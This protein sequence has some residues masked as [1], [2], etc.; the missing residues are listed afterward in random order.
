MKRVKLLV[1][2]FLA[3]VLTSGIALAGTLDD[4]R[5]RGHLIAGVNGGV[6]G[7]SMPD[8]KGV[9]KGLDVDTARAIAV[10]ALARKESRGAHYREDFPNE[11]KNWI[12]HISVR[13]KKGIPDISRIYPLVTN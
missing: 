4:V 2:I 3:V 12:K 8:D 13:L 6:F 11:D 7:F 5:A 1:V 9:W 10:S